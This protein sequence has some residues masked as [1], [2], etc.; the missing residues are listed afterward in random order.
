MENAMHR[1]PHYEIVQTRGSYFVVRHHNGV[2]EV[3][4]R[5]QTEADA[6]EF[7]AFLRWVAAA[8]KRVAAH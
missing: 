4:E 7:F 8:P 2:S 6:E 1:L 3:I 5:F